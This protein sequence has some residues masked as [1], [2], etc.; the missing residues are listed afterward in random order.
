MG[1]GRNRVKDVAQTRMEK[2]LV[3]DDE[4]VV[5][6]LCQKILERGG[7]D[8]VQ[9]NS[10]EA[11]LRFCDASDRSIDLALLDIMMP[12]MNGIELAGHLRSANPKLLIVLMSGCEPQEITRVVGDHP[13]RIIWKPF[14]TE[15]L[16]QM[17]DNAFG[18]STDGMA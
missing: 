5:L 1:W 10:G 18:R 9:A 6:G 13:Y 15:S 7:Y 17:I 14:K 2:I 4:P 8:V 16:L 12:G 3:V 11:A